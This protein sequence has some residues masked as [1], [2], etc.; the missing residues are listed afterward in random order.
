M[1]RV[2]RLRAF[3]VVRA[4]SPGDQGQAYIVLAEVFTAADETERAIQLFERGLE[5]V[6]AQQQGRRALEAGR[7]C[8][9]LLEA[10]GDTAGALRVLRR[11]T[12]AAGVRVRS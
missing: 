1:L 10:E 3:E 6:L 2:L 9:D 12:D 4:M 7:S 8:G 11:A 5:L